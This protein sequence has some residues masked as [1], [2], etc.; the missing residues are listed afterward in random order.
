[1]SLGKCTDGGAD[2]V[3]N[4]FLETLTKVIKITVLAEVVAVYLEFASRITSPHSDSDIVV[5]F[6]QLQFVLCQRRTEI[7]KV[8]PGKVIEQQTID[9]QL[10]QTI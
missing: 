5:N 6:F 9:K 2:S 4:H 7:L 3:C 10:E 8:I 1:M